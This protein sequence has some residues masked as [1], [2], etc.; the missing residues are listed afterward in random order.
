VT[1]SDRNFFWLAVVL[2]GLSTLYAVFLLRKGFREDNRIN[3][4]LLAGAAVLH[5]VAMFKRG[6]SL[7][8]C[9]INNL[10]EATLFVAWTIVTTYLVIGVW[11][12]LRFLGAFVSPLLLSLGVFA[13]W[14][15][16]DVRGPTPTFTGGW[17]SLHKALILLAYG[18]FG[19]GS[20]AGLMYV[21]QD[22]NLKYHKLRAALSLLP[23]IQR[24]EAAVGRLLGAG[25]VLLTAGLI[26]SSIYLKQTRD[27]YMS[28]D[29]LM[30]YSLMVW[31]IYLGLL[32]ARWGYSQRGRRFALG[33][34]GSFAFVLLTFW[35]VYLLSGL[36]QPDTAEGRRLEQRP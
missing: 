19:L 27:V 31:T 3:Y 20:V 33:A 15:D 30:I 14:P 16:L 24:V 36:H 11:S 32:V 29:P 28:A 25:F 22:R 4:I 8:R 12:R 13:L 26:V 7:D 1:L 6:F 23:P 17:A 34:V 18:A 2:Y 9:P 5:T 10:Y 21:I 35:G